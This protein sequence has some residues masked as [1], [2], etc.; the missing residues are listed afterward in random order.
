MAGNFSE[1][2]PDGDGRNLG[3]AVLESERQAQAHIDQ[4]LRPVFLPIINAVA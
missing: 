1:T 2:H 4:K 3:E